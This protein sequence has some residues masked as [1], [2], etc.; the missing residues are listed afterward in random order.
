MNESSC[1][2]CGC[3]LVWVDCYNCNEGEID[4]FDTDPN[5][6]DGVDSCE[7]C[8]ICNGEGGWGRCP[9]CTKEESA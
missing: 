5:W 6:Y 4:M 9:H 3:D 7:T 2:K 8:D 1:K